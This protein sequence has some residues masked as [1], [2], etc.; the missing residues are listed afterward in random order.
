MNCHKN[1]T[2]ILKKSLIQSVI[3]ELYSDKEYKRLDNTLKQKNKVK[4]LWILLVLLIFLSNENDDSRK[5]Y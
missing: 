5:Y 3:E 1:A 4:A 2:I